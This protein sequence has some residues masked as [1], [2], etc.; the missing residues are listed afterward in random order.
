MTNDDVAR[1]ADIELPT[2]SHPCM[3]LTELAKLLEGHNGLWLH[4]GQLKYLT[5][6]IDTRGPRFNLRDRDDRPITMGRIKRAASGKFAETME[7]PAARS[8]SEDTQAKPTPSQAD[9]DALV[10][11]ATELCAAHPLDDAV[12]DLELALTPF[13]KG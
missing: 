3:E 9:V 5:V 4:D 10:K 1:E 7:A 13:Q 11:A 8:E 12:T 2:R 6:H